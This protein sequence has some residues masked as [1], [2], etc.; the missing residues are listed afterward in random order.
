MMTFDTAEVQNSL[1]GKMCFLELLNMFF[2]I[3]HIHIIIDDID[4]DDDDDDIDILVI[5]HSNFFF[6]FTKINIFNLNL[7]NQTSTS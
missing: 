5:S 2:I 6:H 7:I 3:K 4:D 1:I